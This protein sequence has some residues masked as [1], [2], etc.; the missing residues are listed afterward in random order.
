MLQKFEQVRELLGTRI[1]VSVVAENIDD[2]IERAFLECERIQQKYS[3]F[4]ANS[5]L[6]LLN[7]RK[8]ELVEVDKEFFGLLS[9][10]EMVREKTGGCFNLAVKEILE[11]WG[12]DS[13]YSFEEKVLG[14]GPMEGGFIELGEN[15]RRVK[16]TREVDLGA[17]GKGYA[18]DCMVEVLAEFDSFCIDAG[19]DIFAQGFNEKRRP[20]KIAFEHPVNQDEAIGM[21]E[22]DGFFL[23]SS[24]PQKRKWNDK[25][26][27]LNLKNLEPANEMLAVYTQAQSGILADAMSTALFVMGYEKA[28]DF[29]SQKPHF[30]GDYLEAMLISPEG[31]IFKSAD[32]RGEL[33]GA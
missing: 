2:Q 10:G 33:F 19:G 16:I 25:H 6:N 8:G 23:A 29:L 31:A 12:Y 3:C 9:F 30:D 15:D 32:F 27:L 7:A 14:V 28:K 17:L 18:L 5:E 13:E 1:T 22:V 20:W 21:V 11:N 24:N 26:H 4:L